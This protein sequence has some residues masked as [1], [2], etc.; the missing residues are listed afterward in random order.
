MRRAI[1]VGCLLVVRAHVGAAPEADDRRGPPRWQPATGVPALTRVWGFG[2]ELYGVG[3][4][5]AYRSTDSGASWSP[6]DGAGPATGVWGTGS[7]DV[8]IVRAR[9]LHHSHNGVSWTTQT[10]P[11]LSFGAV[12]EGIWGADSDRYVFGVDSTDGKRHG[13]ILRSRDRGTS[14]RSESIPAIERIAA[15]WGSAANDVYAVGAGGVVLHSTGDGTWTIQRKGG[16]SLEGIWGA[17][18]A[19]V[20]A[21]GANGA[22]LHSRD[23]GKTWTP[24]ASGV[25]YTLTSIVGLGTQ[26]L[27]VGSADGPP[28]RSTDGVRWKPITALVSRG[29]V[30]VTDREHAVVA[31]STGV[32]FLGE[33]K[34]VNSVAVAAPTL[35]APMVPYSRTSMPGPPQPKDAADTWLLADRYG[36][37]YPFARDFLRIAAHRLGH[38]AAIDPKLAAAGPPITRVGPVT[39]CARALD[40]Q[41]KPTPGRNELIFEITCTRTCNDVGVKAKT[42]IVDT[43][44][45]VVGSISAVAKVQITSCTHQDAAAKDGLDALRED[46]L[47]K[48]RRSLDKQLVADLKTASNSDQRINALSRYFVNGG[49]NPKARADLASA[50]SRPVTWPAFLWNAHAIP[51]SPAPQPSS[52]QRPVG[53]SSNNRLL[54]VDGL[55]LLRAGDVAAVS[56]FEQLFACDPKMLRLVYVAACQLKQFSKAKKYFARFPA[57]ERDARAQICVKEGF[58]PRTP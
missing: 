12:M 56:K 20:Y 18:A 4:S 40:T 19:S 55:R 47:E 16:G 46:V 9:S 32:Q 11:M 34:P 26:D 30:W 1:V 8:W 15:M 22:I 39:G 36:A 28:L 25:R 5:G 42:T 23:R 29:E 24:R 49:D 17:T 10:L 38:P 13:K 45:S 27:Y 43:N 58:D 50:L 41:V 6:A 48:L 57:T 2:R 54:L 31:A 44:G 51:P 7:D 14:W 21:V 35:T 33:S 53:C 52:A 3:Q 37:S